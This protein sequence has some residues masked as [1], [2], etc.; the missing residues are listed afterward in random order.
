MLDVCF[1]S[2]DLLGW[3]LSRPRKCLN[4]IF[5]EHLMNYLAADR[6]AA[7]WWIES[8]NSNTVFIMI[9]CISFG[10]NFWIFWQASPVHLNFPR[11]CHL[12]LILLTHHATTGNWNQAEVYKRPSEGSKWTSHGT[13]RSRWT[14][15]TGE[16][17]DTS[18]PTVSLWI[19]QDILECL[20]QCKLY[21]PLQACQLVCLVLSC[22]VLSC[23]VLSCLVVFCFVLV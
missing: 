16:A 8:P 23:L 21:M 11:T 15:Q 6:E 12:H 22:L 3:Y 9:L 1:R 20:V 14:Q 4:E 5:L 10:D 7:L 13:V 19:L 2:W 18:F 17:K